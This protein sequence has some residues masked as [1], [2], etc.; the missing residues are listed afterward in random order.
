M[1]EE[2]WR[3]IPELETHEVSS[4]GRARSKDRISKVAADGLGGRD[5]VVQYER[6]LKGRLLSPHFTGRYIQYCIND[7]SYLAHRL[8]ASAFLK[9]DRPEQTIINHKDGNGYNNRVD[10]LEWCTQSENEHHSYDVLGKQVWNKGKHYVNH[11]GIETRRRNHLK[12]CMDMLELRESGMSAKQI[13]EQYQCCEWQVHSNLKK[14]RKH[15]E[16]DDGKVQ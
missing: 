3:T 1:L 15:K 11:V 7:R 8:V 9:K 12:K 6:K 5:G 2:E 13:A 10:N 4:M 14:A 16:E